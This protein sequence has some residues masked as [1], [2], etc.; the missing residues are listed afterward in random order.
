MSSP[1]VVG[2]GGELPTPDPSA[3]SLVAKL[4]RIAN[5]IG[6][7]EPQVHNSRADGDDR[8]IRFPYHSAKDV[9]GWWR[10]KLQTES[11]LVV[12]TKVLD[13]QV[14]AVELPRARGGTRKTFLTT[15]T[16]QFT[17]RDGIT[18]EWIEAIGVGQG[19]DPSDKGVGKAMT[20]AEKNMLLGMGMNGSEPDV[21]A[22]PSPEERDREEAARDTSREDGRL[23]VNVTDSAITGIERGGRSTGVTEAQISAIKRRAVELGIGVQGIVEF[24][25]VATKQQV[26]LPDD[27]AQAGPALI[28]HLNGMTGDDIGLVIQAMDNPP[29][30]D[31]A[32][33]PE[34]FGDGDGYPG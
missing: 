1:L 7:K 15:L 6:T 25:Y 30:A 23:E 11:L 2:A 19:E 27:P 22:F 14:L 9:Y 5:E 21:E 12:P 31:D 18:G 33:E 20:Y 28:A 32:R 17:I 16:V 26:R 34:G 29:A 8:G 24:V 3:T 13:L 10:P 4:A